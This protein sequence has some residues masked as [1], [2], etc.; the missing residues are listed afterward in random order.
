[1]TSK[2]MSNSEAIYLRSFLLRKGNITPFSLWECTDRRHG[3]QVFGDIGYTFQD[4]I[5]YQSLR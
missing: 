1:M 5:S 2:A 3:L 4:P